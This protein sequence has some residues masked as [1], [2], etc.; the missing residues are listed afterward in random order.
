MKKAI[1]FVLALV[2]FAVIQAGLAEAEIRIDFPEKL[3]IPATQEAAEKAGFP[4]LDDYG[5]C[6]DYGT[7]LYYPGCYADMEFLFNEQEVTVGDYMMDS[8]YAHFSNA[9][10]ANCVLSDVTKSYTGPGDNHLSI[11]Y[12][13]N[14]NITGISLIDYASQK[15]YAY[16]GAY[17]FSGY[18]QADEPWVDLDSF[19]SAGPK[20]NVSGTLDLTNGYDGKVGPEPGIHDIVTEVTKDGVTYKL[21]DKNGTATATKAKKSLKKAVIPA[22]VKANNTTYKVTAIADSAFKG[23]KKLTTLTIG[24]NV[25]KIGKRA[26]YQCEKLTSITIS[27]S[28][29]TKNS[30]GKEAFKGTPKTVKIKV[31]KKQLELY[32]TILVKAGVY[33]KAKITK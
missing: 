14:L 19:K 5:C 25:K 2:L 8:C 27:T 29:L 17:K 33:K 28:S 30:I 1:L 20:V 32:R 24:K 21:N 23:L 15:Q 31:P 13:K 10:G 22:S 9:G 6:L 11:F 3:I 16:G 4:Y 7:Y 26:F 12:D 18:T